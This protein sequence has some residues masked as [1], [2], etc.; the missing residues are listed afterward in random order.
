M[1]KTL[2]SKNIYKGRI[3]NLRVDEVEL[4]DGRHTTREIVEHPGAAAIVPLDREGRVHFVS[5]Y[6]DA[7]E[8]ELL[9]IPAGKLKPGEAPEDCAQRELEEEMG[10][11][12]GRL[13]HLATFYSTPG[14]CN[15]IMHMFLAEDLQPGTGEVDREEFLRLE[16]RPLEPLADLVKE[17]RDAKSVAGILLTQLELER[18]RD[19]REDA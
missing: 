14:F 3:I 4:P 16:S 2:S 12:G 1:N 17:L 13:T 7:V 11:I 19:A 9:E 8:E 6:R 18:R 15:E 5:Q 10:F